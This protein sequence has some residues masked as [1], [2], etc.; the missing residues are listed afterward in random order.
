M[1]KC[2]ILI[3]FLLMQAHVYAAQ[4]NEEEIVDRQQAFEAYLS[5][6]CLLV[7]KCQ[8]KKECNECIMKLLSDMDNETKRRRY[9]RIESVN[10]ARELVGWRYF[11]TEDAFERV[12]GKDVD[13][14]NG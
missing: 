7:Q 9:P 5:S 14:N 4:N 10:P 11:S 3:I 2:E 1:K 8:T 12:Y 6:Y 13:G